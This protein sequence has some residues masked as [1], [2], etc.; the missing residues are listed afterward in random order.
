[1]KLQ[2]SFDFNSLSEAISIAKSV[3]EFADIIEVGTLLLYKE[4]VKAISEFKKEFPSKPIFVD[5]KICEKAKDSITLLAKAGANIISILAG[6]SN[7][8]IYEASQIA[9][10]NNSK[11]ALDLIDSY[12]PAESCTQAKKLGIDFILFHKSQEENQGISII[13]Q[14]DSLKVNTDLPILVSGKINRINIEKILFLKP[15]GLIIGRGITRATNP[16]V[17]A[18]YFRSLINN[19]T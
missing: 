1:M 5:A 10:E 3:A 19:K 16:E 4:G 12:S 7:K 9:H 2:I 14:W 11:I 8:I 18:E 13:D 6:T 15:D 17:E